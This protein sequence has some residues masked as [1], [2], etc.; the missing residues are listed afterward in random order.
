MA[1]RT[2]SLVFNVLWPDRN[3][4]E[5]DTSHPRLQEPRVI[6]AG[7]QIR[8]VNTGHVAERV[9]QRERDGLLLGRLAQRHAD[10]AQHDVVDA[11]GEGD[12]DEDGDEAGGDVGGDGG[13]DEADDDDALADCDVPGT[14]V[15]AAGG[16]THDDSHGG[17]EQVGRAGEGEGGGGVVAEGA[18]DGGQEALEADR[19]D[20]GVV[21]QAEDPG[22][23]VGEGLAQSDPDAGG[24]LALRG[25]GCDAPVGELAF[26]LV[27]PA[28]L[29]RVVWQEEK[30]GTCHTDGESALDDEEPV[31]E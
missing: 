30:G 17:G 13:D 10:P 19:R 27:Q 28:G 12:E 29:E 25:V 9:A 3:R 4:R 6:R 31:F 20:V 1:E 2:G 11:E 7:P 18:Y 21:H 5:R 26:G 24:F 22:T 15:V 16:V 14:L 23:P 8:R